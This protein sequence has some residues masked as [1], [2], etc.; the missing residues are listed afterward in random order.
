MELSYGKT[1]D[2]I[3]SRESLFKKIGALPE[4]SQE[5]L[6]TQWTH[7]IPDF[8][9]VAGKR[10]GNIHLFPGTKNLLVNEEKEDRKEGSWQ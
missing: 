2:Q 3:I 9:P 8:V 6:A 1:P 7:E 10:F 5:I 4:K